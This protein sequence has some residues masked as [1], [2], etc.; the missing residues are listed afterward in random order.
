[1]R[2]YNSSDKVF[3]KIFHKPSKKTNFQQIAY[4]YLEV[5]SLPLTTAL[6]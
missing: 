1:M 5:E 2:P 4:L 6:Y 3:Q